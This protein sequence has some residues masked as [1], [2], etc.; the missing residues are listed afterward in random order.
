V[1]GPERTELTVRAAALYLPAVLAIGLAWWARPD[2][3]R[4][5]GV[6]LASLWNLA[7]LLPVSML[8]VRAGWWRF[9]TDWVLVG[10]MP[11]DL[12]IGWA[13]LWGTVP[14]L[15][16]RIG[17][18][19]AVV[20]LVGADLVLMPMAEPVLV[21]GPGWLVGEAAAVAVALVPGLALG[22]WTV[23][24]ERLVAR[25]VMQ[26]ITFTLL[27]FFVVPMVAFSLTGDGWAPLLARP[28]PLLVAVGLG[29]APVV[30]MA[31][32]GMREFCAA[33]GTPFPLDPPARLVATG[34]Y[35]YLANPMQ[36]AGT[37]LLAV[38]GLLLG[39]AAVVGATAVA[40]AFSAGVAAWS[41][42]IELV[43]RFGADWRRYRGQA[44]V[45]WPRW[46]P[47]AFERSTV[48]VAASCESC[49]EVGAFLVARHPTGLDV[50][51]AEWCPFPLE[52]ITHVHG[53]TRTTGIAAVARSLEHVNLAWAAGGWVA[54]LP[55][56]VHVLQVIADAVGAGPRP[57]A[58]R[59]LP[60]V[61]DQSVDTALRE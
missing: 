42:E 1:T 53:L 51:P 17:A 54:R 35:A 32:Q 56:I 25:V 16:P 45:W 21:L 2:R 22:W 15:V 52:R 46:R 33:G 9:A 29:V 48:Y 18:V 50:V 5:A 38:W 57:V 44:R 60:K 39:S 26:L 8:A 13:L 40:G 58:R 19:P 12:W 14:M 28:R 10:G 59:P 49:C 3:R 31:L 55:G 61:T 41:E 34:P 23:G 36:A 37:I 24:E 47:I 11:A 4:I 6:C 27:L 30:A 20:G 43:Q 7:V